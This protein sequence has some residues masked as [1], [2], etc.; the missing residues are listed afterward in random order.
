M[1][2]GFKPLA[3]DIQYAKLTRLS[4]MQELIGKDGLARIRRHLFFLHSAVHPNVNAASRLY[5]SLAHD[6]L[7]WVHIL[8]HII[9]QLHL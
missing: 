9:Q 6:S 1:A 3:F 7:R 8:D 4:S 5:G 2:I